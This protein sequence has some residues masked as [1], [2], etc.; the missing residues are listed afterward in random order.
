[1]K[2]RITK[3]HSHQ[4]FRKAL[5]IRYKPKDIKNKH[6]EYWNWGKYLRECVEVFGTQMAESDIPIFFH[7]SISVNVI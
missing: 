5:Y 4:H 3:E 1:M 2:I 6:R 7:G